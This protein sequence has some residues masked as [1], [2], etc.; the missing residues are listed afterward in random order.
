MQWKSIVGTVALAIVGFHDSAAGRWWYDKEGWKEKSVN[1]SS[2]MIV[3]ISH[4]CPGPKNNCNLLNL[5]D[6]I[7]FCS[8]FKLDLCFCVE[9][10]SQR[11]FVTIW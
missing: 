4:N 9:S 10:G 6:F 5:P 3:N 1:I 7:L 8:F 2:L 11:L